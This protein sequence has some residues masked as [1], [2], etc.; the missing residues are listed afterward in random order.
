MMNYLRFFSLLICGV[1]FNI[2]HWC[3]SINIFN[4]FFMYFNAALVLWSAKLS[5]FHFSILTNKLKSNNLAT[6]AWVESTSRKNNLI[7]LNH[8]KKPSPV[9]L[10]IL[11]PAVNYT[12]SQG[13]VS[14]T[15]CWSQREAAA[16][17]CLIN[18]LDIDTNQFGVART[19]S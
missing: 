19:R 6:H 12:L 16:R 5:V 11:K 1:V 14:S 18:Q 3:F 13:R 8:S 4:Y 7:L 15:T 10:S 2:W 17:F 9:S